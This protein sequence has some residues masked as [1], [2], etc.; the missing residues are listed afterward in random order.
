MIGLKGYIYAALAAAALAAGGYVVLLQKR[1]ER[2]AA[3]LAREQANRA[4][5]ERQLEQ[6]RESQAVADAWA[7]NYRQQSERAAAI[8]AQIESNP[9]AILDAPL[10]PDVVAGLRGLLAGGTAD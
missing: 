3:D 1:A 8:I 2:L 7:E 6:A 9:D 4:V 5:V 10:P